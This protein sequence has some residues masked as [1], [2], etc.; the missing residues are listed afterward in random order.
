MRRGG[1]NSGRDPL[2]PRRGP[3]RVGSCGHGSPRHGSENANWFL[4]NVNL[5][6]AA[7]SYNEVATGGEGRR[8][9]KA[10]S[11]RAYPRTTLLT[12]RFPDHDP[13]RSADPPAVATPDRGARCRHLGR[14]QSPE[15]PVDRLRGQRSRAGLL[16]RSVR[17]DAEPGPLG[18]RGRTVPAGLCRPGRLQPVPRECADR[19]VSAPARADRLGNLGLPHVPRGHAER[20]AQPEGGRLPDGDD[21]KTAHQPGSGLSVRLP[22]DPQ[23]QLQPQGPGRL[24]EACRGFHASRRAAVFPQRQLPRG[25]RSVAAA[26]GRFAGASA[27]GRRGQGHALPGNRPAGDARDGGRLLQLPQPPGHAGGRPAGRAASL[28]QVPEHAGDLLGRPRRGHAP[29]QTH[30][31]RGRRADP[32]AGAVARTCATASARGVGLDG[33]PDAHRAHGL[34]RRRGAR[35]AGTSAAA[36]AGRRA[37]F[38]AHAAVHRVPHARRRA[39]LPSAA[40]RPHRPL[41][42][43]REPPAG[44]AESGLRQHLPQ[45]GSGRHRPRPRGF[46][47]RTFPDHRRRRGGR[48]R[49]LRPDGETSAVRVVRSTGRSVRVPQPRRLARPCRRVRRTATS[50]RRMARGDE[51]PPA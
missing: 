4:Q 29:R 27:N 49:R 44:H 14:E 8:S 40:R 43:H 48:P 19:A 2:G 34:R 23:R 11:S 47:G 12:S 38:V 5:R 45:A 10:W 16:R 7:S 31:L 37:D 13:H 30:L 41:Q 36:V 51:R 21:R 46:R 15:H 1:M 9:R 26:S 3:N 24:C 28:G 6:Q 32:A 50:A 25:A 18:R 20:P 42:A 33:G 17:A 35:P 22:R 39:E